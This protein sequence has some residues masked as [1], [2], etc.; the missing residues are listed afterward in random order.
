MVSNQTTARCN[1]AAY[2]AKFDKERMLELMN[3]H[4]S[5]ARNIYKAIAKILI[6]YAR[7]FY[8]FSH[9]SKSYISDLIDTETHYLKLDQNTTT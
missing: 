6:R 9:L 3:N 4:P 2:I 1:H 7:E 5:L 8:M